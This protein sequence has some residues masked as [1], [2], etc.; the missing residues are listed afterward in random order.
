[1]NIECELWVPCVW[2]NT[3][4]D[5]SS[6]QFDS[7]VADLEYLLN[8]THTHVFK[9]L[10]VIT[11]V[12]P[13]RRNESDELRALLKTEIDKIKAVQKNT[14]AC[15]KTAACGQIDTSLIELKFD[16]NTVSTLECCGKS[17]RMRSHVCQQCAVMYVSNVQPCMSA[18]CSHVGQHNLS[19]QL[20]STTSRVQW[21]RGRASNS[22][23]RRSM[24]K[25]CAAAL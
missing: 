1:M 10:H 20:V 15:P 22:R 19:A 11:T 14:A 18:M 21:L 13:A 2:I 8:L 9:L 23:L 3:L 17:T 6:D 12:L 24:F 7:I 25:S 5:A 4:S 16:F